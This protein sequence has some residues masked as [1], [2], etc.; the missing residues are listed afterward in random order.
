MRAE[1]S[2]RKKRGNQRIREKPAEGYTEF[3]KELKKSK[4][5]KNNEIVTVLGNSMEHEDIPIIWKG[6]DFFTHMLVVGATRSGKTASILEPMIYQLL[7]QK[8]QGKK[9]GLSVIE[10]K[11]GFAR[12]VKSFCD[13]LDIPYIYIDPER[14]NE[15]NRFNPMEGEINDVA[16]ATVVVLKGLFGKQD[17]FFATVQELS[18][19]N[20]TKLLK[21]LHGDDMDIIDVM[22][23]LRDT[24]VL[25][26]KVE[27]LKARDGVTDLVHFF[28][29]ELLGNMADKYRQ[30]VIGL[31]AQLENITS[32]DM[33]REIMTGRSDMDIDK[34]FEEGGVLIV[35]TSLGKL[36]SAGDAFGQFIIMHLQNGTFRREGTEKSRIPHFMIVDEYSRY[37]NPDV[38]IFLSL[39][40]EYKVS[41]IL[42]TQSLG[43]LEIESGKIGARAMKK[44]IMTNCR[45]KLCFGGVSSD[46]A[47]EFADEFGKDKIIV[48]QST[49]KH[50]IFMPVLFPDSYR[51]TESEE[52]RFDPTD[53]MDNLPKYNY[54]HKMMYDGQ[55]QKPSLAVGDIVPENWQGLRE[56][57][58][59]RLTT[60]L[61][62]SG[63]GLIK[64]TKRI[65]KNSPKDLTTPTKDVLTEAVTEHEADPI[66]SDNLIKQ[67]NPSSPLKIDQDLQRSNLES[68]HMKSTSLKE[69]K[70]KKEEVST[71]PSSHDNFW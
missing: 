4:H 30:F 55:M 70:S 61:R 40:A 24:T 60:K 44:T 68:I 18:A 45:N 27:D 25:K 41:G 59:K 12:K 16:E 36:K 28:E 2:Y 29:A 11:G 54:I 3:K 9:L 38:E 22:N 34:H 67:D 37:I 63:A 66:K 35:N 52:Y 42:A 65:L 5:R 58:D 71:P 53:I 6:K 49:Y 8:K 51:D 23:T 15:S 17:A 39:A 69:E 64:Q 26:Q 56:W 57:E 43:Q 14:I 32:N 62:N 31:R 7:L 50:R 19:R 48:R 33:L 13:E 47:Q 21:E 1:F 10:P 20:V 46:D